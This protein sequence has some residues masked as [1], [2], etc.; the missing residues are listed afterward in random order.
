MI[1]LTTFIIVPNLTLKC[2]GEFTMMELAEIVK[3][4]NLFLFFLA[5]IEFDSFRPSPLNRM[6]K[7]L[8]GSFSCD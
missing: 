5:T 6:N 4:V 3:E 2:V 8:N 1:R 7:Q